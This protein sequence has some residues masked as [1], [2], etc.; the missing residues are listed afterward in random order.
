MNNIFFT[1]AWR[2]C[3]AIPFVE[4]I[5]LFSVMDMASA[6]LGEMQALHHLMFCCVECGKESQARRILE[7]RY[8]TFSFYFQLVSLFKNWRHGLVVKVLDS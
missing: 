4:V 5:T 7:V 8:Q 2:T 6:N 1:L 3:R